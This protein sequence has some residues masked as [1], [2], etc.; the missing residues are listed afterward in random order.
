MQFRIYIIFFRVHANSCINVFF[1]FST[2][3]IFKYDTFIIRSFCTKSSLIA[4]IAIMNFIIEYG[5]IEVFLHI[6][7]SKMLIEFSIQFF[8]VFHT[9]KIFFGGV[10][11]SEEVRE[12]YSQHDSYLLDKQDFHQIESCYSN[13]RSF[14]QKFAE[15]FLVLAI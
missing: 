5:F 7:H 3:I 2:C 8:F 13:A 4:T 6:L 9:F 10:G 1:G 15:Y 14:G 11:T 12:E